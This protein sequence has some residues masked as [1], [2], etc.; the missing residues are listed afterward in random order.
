M[1]RGSTFL[2]FSNHS[3]LV[4]VLCQHEIAQRVRKE[5][6]STSH[7]ILAFLTGSESDRDSKVCPDMLSA[8]L[9]DHLPLKHN[10]S[11][12]DST[13]LGHLF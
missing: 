12:D 11:S 8:F 4:I 5:E 3:G 10:H 1:G 2:F 6:G 13:A 9:V 7:L